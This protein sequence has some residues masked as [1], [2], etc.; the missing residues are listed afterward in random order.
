MRKI[1]L[2]FKLILRAKFIF[3][4]PEKHDLIIFDEMS[5]ID[6][7]ICLSKFNFFVL[8]TRLEATSKIYFS[9]KILKKIFRNYFRGNLFTVYLVSL[10]ELIKP[11]AV[12]TT[13]DNSFKFSDVA[14]ILEEKTNFIA[15]QNASRLDL[16]EFNHFYNTKKTKHNLLKK[17]YIPNLFCFGEYE[18]ELYKQLDIKVK[19]L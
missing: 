13:I 3:K 12:I 16:L 15:I 5:V 18:R 1:I 11:K 2:F 19:N 6:L 10:I 7:N 14:K 4:T 8:E 17:F 9:Y